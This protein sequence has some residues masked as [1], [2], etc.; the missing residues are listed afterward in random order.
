MSLDRQDLICH[1]GEDAR[2]TDSEPEGRGADV[3]QECIRPRLSLSPGL[4]GSL[5]NTTTTLAS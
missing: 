3:E 2:A 5:P 1:D 4:R